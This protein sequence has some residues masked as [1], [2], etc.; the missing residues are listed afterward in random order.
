[1]EKRIAEHEKKLADFKAN[2]TIKPGM[3]GL[4]KEVIEAVNVSMAAANGP[5][6]PTPSS[7]STPPALTVEQSKNLKRFEKKL[8]AGATE[9]S[10]HDLPGGGKAFQ[11]EVPGSKA[12]YEKQVGATGE[13][14]QYTKTTPVIT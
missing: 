10:V 6:S 3:K 1:M 5:P 12:I 14:L 4:P 8:P 7:P 13:T 9:T 11:A 2:P